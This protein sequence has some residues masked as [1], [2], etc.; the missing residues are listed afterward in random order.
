MKTTDTNI[1][2]PTFYTYLRITS[3]E[4]WAACSSA[5]ISSM[6]K[7]GFFYDAGEFGNCSKEPQDWYEDGSAGAPM[8]FRGNKPTV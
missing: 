6:R 4:D 3:K 2:G 1:T 7:K 5:L 8:F